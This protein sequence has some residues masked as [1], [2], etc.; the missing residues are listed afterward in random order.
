M[1]LLSL[2]VWRRADR[3]APSTALVHRPAR[4]WLPVW[5]WAAAATC[6]VGGAGLMGLIGVRAAVLLFGLLGGVWLLGVLFR[7]TPRLYDRIVIGAFALYLALPSLLKAFGL[8]FFGPLQGLVYALAFKG[9]RPMWRARRDMPYLQA[10]LMCFAAFMLLGLATSFVGRSSFLAAA[11]Q[12]LSNLK[13]VLLV[14]LGFAVAWTAAGEKAF[15]FLV[16]WAWLPMLLLV[17]FEWAAPGSY[18][19]VFPYSGGLSP[20][21]SGLLPSRAKGLFEHPSFLANASAQLALLCLATAACRPAG[22]RLGPTLLGVAYLV[23]LVTSAQRGEQFSLLMSGL[24]AAIVVMQRAVKRRI[25]L[26]VSVVL[27]G[28]GFWSVFSADIAREA[29]TWGIGSSG[30]VEHP[31][32][33]IFRGAFEVASREFPLGSGLGT[34]GGAGAEKF[35][36]S[37]YDELGFRQYWWYL[38]EDYLMDTYWPNSIAETGYIGALLL[39]SSY[40][41]LSVAAAVRARACLQ[42]QAKA[43]W[44][45]ACCGMWFMLG[46]SFSSPTFQ[47]PRLFLLVAVM[48]GI[49]YRAER[50][51]G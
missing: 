40:L 24:L 21:P 8:A 49:A 34:Y 28:L 35:D 14:A 12:F 39:L 16:R 18:Q 25:V 22:R 6:A 38:V 43:Y 10:A 11:F 17:G 7:G 48:F 26:S 46:N 44:V 3:P 47:D 29:T 42:P 37:L 9:V 36:L 30:Q 32:A 41:L 4:D 1:A 15:W 13:P 51:H 20:D 19:K 45:T 50:R 2:P 23:T 5:I 27:L 33:Q 31:R